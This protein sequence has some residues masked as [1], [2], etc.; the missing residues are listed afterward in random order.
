MRKVCL[1]GTSSTLKDAPLSDTSFEFWA[2]NN[3][4]VSITL[5]GVTKWFQIHSESSVRA[6]DQ[7]EHFKKF[8]PTVQIYMQK[9]HDE[10]PQS[11]AYPLD[12]IQAKYRG[13][14]QSTL[15]YM[16]AL[17]LYEGDINE[18]H[19]YGVDMATN[20][21]YAYQRPSMYYW[22]GRAEQAG[23]KVVLPDNCDLL[24]CYYKYG[25]EDEKKSDIATKLRARHAEL[26][27]NGNA[28]M[29]D[30][31]LSLGAKDT[32]AFYLREMGEDL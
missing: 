1:L 32:C 18:I 22:L 26:D 11:V 2:L 20:T 6:S 3:M 27:R 10:I 14:F 31:Y 5:E 4:Y 15:D 17:A 9:Q 25:Y 16:I 19:I 29:K 12:E 8:P 13:L 30:Y 7:W 28:Q 21:E 24:K 23:I